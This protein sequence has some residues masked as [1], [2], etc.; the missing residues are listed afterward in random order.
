MPSLPSNPPST[1][2]NFNNQP[3]PPS[4]Y[5]NFKVEPPTPMSPFDFPQVPGK[6]FY[7]SLY[8]SSLKKFLNL[9]IISMF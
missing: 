3:M 9:I 5:G 2:N 1:T 4:I 6:H 8:F 7:I